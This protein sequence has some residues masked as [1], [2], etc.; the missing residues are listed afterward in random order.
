MNKNTHIALDLDK[1]IATYES[2]WRARKVGDPIVPMVSNI[3]KWLNKGYKV[4]IFTA[5]LAKDNLQEIQKQEKMISGFLR[6]AG[7]PQLPM[8]CIKHAHFTHFLDDKAFHVIP[9]TGQIQNCPE[10]LL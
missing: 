9:N 6:S 10:E 7:L 8:T 2:N 4:S 5:R 1:T 3:L